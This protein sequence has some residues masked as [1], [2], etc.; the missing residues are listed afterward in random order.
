MFISNISK[1]IAKKVH[2][3]N[4]LLFNDKTNEIYVLTDFDKNGQEF[5][6]GHICIEKF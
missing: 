3:C 1:E 6:I 4:E 5:L 2:Y